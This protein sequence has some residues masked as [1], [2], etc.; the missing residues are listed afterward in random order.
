M[1]TKYWCSAT[2]WVR[3]VR[4]IDQRGTQARSRSSRLNITS[5][6]SWPPKLW[7]PQRQLLL[8]YHN[9]RNGSPPPY[10]VADIRTYHN[11]VD[12]YDLWA[13][14]ERR[15]KGTFRVSFYS[16]NFLKK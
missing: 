7:R 14:I 8:G 1:A 2:D 11:G 13:D 5:S 15:M 4:A 12:D 6:L 10:G 9:R 16:D 3:R